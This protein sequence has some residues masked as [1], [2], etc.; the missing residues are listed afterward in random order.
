MERLTKTG[1]NLGF[2]DSNTLPNYEAVYE[3]L[4]KYEDLEEECIREHTWGLKIL[5]K[6]WKEFFEDIQ[7]L[8]EYRNLKKQG[9]ILELV[10]KVGDKIWSITSLEDYSSGEYKENL[11]VHPQEKK[12]VSITMSK[13]GILYHVKDRAFA[14]FEFGETVFLTKEEA[15]QALK[16]Q[17]EKNNEEEY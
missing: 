14:G 1:I 17:E 7:E 5:L 4:R 9:K 2:I 16:E 12:I 13:N 8:Y 10:C 15:E 6:K 11:L 3:R